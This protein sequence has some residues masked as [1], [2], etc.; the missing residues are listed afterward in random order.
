MAK[1][2]RGYVDED[3]RNIDF[4]PR[5]LHKEDEIAPGIEELGLPSSILRD[6]TRTVT[7]APAHFD[8]PSLPDFLEGLKAKQFGHVELGLIEKA[9]KKPREVLTTKLKDL[10]DIGEISDEVKSFYVAGNKVTRFVQHRASLDQLKLRMALL[11]RK[12]RQDVIDAAIE[13]ATSTKPI[14]TLKV[15]PPGEDE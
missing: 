6:V 3:P 2:P 7:L 5:N 4:N 14:V 10:W 13:E 12:V 11:K 8:Y 1:K 9:A 15:T